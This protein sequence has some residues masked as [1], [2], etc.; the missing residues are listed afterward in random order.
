MAIRF[1]CTH[2]GQK[3]K[4]QDDMSGLRIACPTCR[5]RQEV[6]RPPPGKDSPS[7]ST[8]RADELK[9]QLAAQFDPADFNSAPKGYQKQKRQNDPDDHSEP[10]NQIKKKRILRGSFYFV[11]VLAFIPLFLYMIQPNSEQ[12]LVKLIEKGIDEDLHGKNKSLARKAFE[13]AKKGRASLE[14]VINLFP[15][16]KLKSAWLSRDSD[17]YLY[18]ALVST[19]GFLFVTCICLPKGFSRIPLMLMIGGFTGVF[20]I[21]MLL[22]LQM[23]AQTGWGLVIGGPFAIIIYMIGIAYRA[24]LDPDLPFINCLLSYTFG[25]GLC[26]EIIKALPIFLIFLGRS[27]QRWH[28]CCALGMASGIGFGIAEGIMF[29]GSMYNGLADQLT[30][31]VRFI[32]CVMLH[33]I[34]CAASALFLHRFQKLT[35]GGMTFLTGFYRMVILISIPMVLHGLYDTLLT[36]HMD[37]MALAIALFSFGWLVLMVESAREKEGDI[38]VE[39]RNVKEEITPLHDLPKSKPR[40][41]G[42]DHAVSPSTV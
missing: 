3:I 7:S 14:E 12:N 31:Y 5:E 20:G 26:E 24:L 34:W 23:L 16:K 41:E 36:K 42:S 27:R 39:V 21:G 4:A 1:Y 19:V 9:L 32:S 18:L 15:N 40:R 35:H 11:F 30:Y 25:V 28:E 13:E 33:A 38:L 10:L 22:I 8:G 37:G 6:P 17:L 29:S 2:C